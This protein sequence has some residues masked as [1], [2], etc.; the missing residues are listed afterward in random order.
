MM[1]DAISG[2]FTNVLNWVG[3]FVTALVTGITDGPN[4]TSLLPLFAIGIG[5]SLVMVCCKLVRKITWGS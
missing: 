2:A 5:V 4:L 1:L 3:T